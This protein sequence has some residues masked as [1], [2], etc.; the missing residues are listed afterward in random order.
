MQAIFQQHKFFVGLLTAVLFLAL[1]TPAFAAEPSSALEEI[2]VSVTGQEMAVAEDAEKLDGVDEVFLGADG[3]VASLVTERGFESDVKLLVGVGADGAVTGIYVV[4]QGETPERGGKALE[5]EYLSQFV[6]RESTEGI[7]AF[8]GATGTSNAV[9]TAVE[10]AICQY[11]A[12]N[13]IAYEAEQTAEEKLEAALA[14]FLG[15]E[16]EACGEE[17]VNLVT[18][19]W[20]SD[21]GYCFL[22]E[23]PGYDE[24]LPIRLL[25]CLDAKGFVREINVL[26]QHETLDNGSQAFAE[27]YLALYE[28]GSSFTVFDGLPGTKIDTLSGA[29]E[30]CY[31]VFQLIN[32]ATMQY[33]RATGAGTEMLLLF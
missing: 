15:E 31:S 1:L 5:E 13:G 23:K 10:T 30:S 32:A 22:T 3:A 11:K 26:E 9:F 8:S 24:A 6:G 29:T 18:G 33:S 28:G 7:D 12:V 2:L 4:A 25:V 27:N 20:K 21:K 14:G 16:Y 17:L 19:A